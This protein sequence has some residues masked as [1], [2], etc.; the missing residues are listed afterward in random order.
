MTDRIAISLGLLILAAI[1]WDLLANDS[2]AFLFLLRKF[3]D[4]IE[5]LS[6]WR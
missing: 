4:F 3:A 1:G 2:R 5:Y 6:F